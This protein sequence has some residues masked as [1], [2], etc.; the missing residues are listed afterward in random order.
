M[1]EHPALLTKLQAD[2]LVD[3]VPEDADYADFVLA[4]ANA[5][6]KK[7]MDWLHTGPCRQHPLPDG[8]LHHNHMACPDCRYEVR[9]ATEL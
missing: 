3:T 9:K 4:G 1:S 6:V 8:T 5:Q 2:R 7:L